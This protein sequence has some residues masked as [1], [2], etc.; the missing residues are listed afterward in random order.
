[1]R[2]KGARISGLLDVGCAELAAF[3]FDEC[4]FDQR[5][6]LN[7]AEAK[8]VGFTDCTL[9]GLD[10]QRL[11]CTGPV[12]MVGSRIL[13]PVRMQDSNISGDLLL[14]ASKIEVA[15]AEVAIEIQG[16]HIAN[17]LDIRDVHIT[18]GLSMSTAQIDGNF[19]LN[20]ARL[21]RPDSI[22]LYA[23]DL[24]IG[25]SI[26]GRSGVQVS[27]SVL[28]E[29]STVGGTVEL[30]RIEISR[31]LQ[32]ALDLDHCRFSMGFR[33]EDA[34]IRGTIR[35]HHMVAG[36]QVTLART[37]VDEIEKDMD[38]VH[39][40]HLEVDGAA[41]FSDVHLAGPLTLH[42]A[43]I[44]CD[45]HIS[46]AKVSSVKTAPAFQANGAQIGNDL[47]ARNC[48]IDGEAF[49]SAIQIDGNAIFAGAS[50]TNGSADALDLSRAIVK[51]SLIAT[52]SFSAIG[53]V[54]LTNA[55]VGV[56]LMLTEAALK[57]PR[58]IA[59]A[60]SGV[61]VTG[62]MIADRC[63]MDGLVDLASSLL[64]G[65]LRFV[66]ATL[67][68]LSADESSLGAAVDA[69]GEWRGLAMRCTGARIA[70]NVDLRGAKLKRELM[71]N[72]ATIGRSVHLASIHLATEGPYALRADGLT[73]D[74]LVLK[75]ASQPIHAISLASANIQELVD[76]VTSWPQK[77]H[78]NI[79]G[80]QYSRLDSDVSIS[81]RLAWLK[82][83]T[84]TYAAQP[85]EKLAACLDLAGQQGD[86]RAVR[87]ASVRRAHR[88]KNLMIHMWGNLQ[89][90]VIGYGYAPIR[91]LVIFAVLLVGAGLWF[92]LGVT[93]C[94]S[95]GWGL[96]PVK[97]DEHPTWDPWLYALDLLIPLVDLGHEKS[98]DPLGLSKLVAMILIMS[99]WVL[100]TTVIA[101]ASRTLRRT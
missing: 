17:D 22:A 77:A 6:F 88:S 24:V 83:A 100:T 58:G 44:T 65:D 96:C 76:D 89:D 86:A 30:N 75:P 61:R 27:G 79:S 60:A 33:C 95:T 53:S 64:D 67:L 90:A 101:A 94:P 62:D 81:E 54:K 47:L 97:A 43:K 72:S 63:T 13:G 91:A 12:W 57:N 37:K 36:C 56:N 29:N 9:Q 11:R 7:D 31:P 21:V 84:P 15:Q 70:G 42:G 59:L 98:W 85:Y 50:I 2:L 52:G 45:L 20:D 51:G 93:P 25:G 69:K 41:H 34:R 10:A 38:A 1:M 19:L 74:T 18:G 78:I 8:F 80:L 26:F 4:V 14:T 87:L 5:P 16:A 46:G 92:S 55:F 32:I 28:L 49:M 99:G 39:A 35:L 68:G 23:P 82:R 66:D 48:I 71:L 73:A 40:N 3:H